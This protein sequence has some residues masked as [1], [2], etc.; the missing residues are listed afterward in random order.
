MP[1]LKKLQQWLEQLAQWT[2][3]LISWLALALVLVTVSI[4]ILRYLFDFGSI[5][6][7]ES[8]VY[9]HAS[10]F[11]LGGAYT[12]KQDGHVRVDIFY[13]R[14]TPEQKAWVNLIGAA[15]FLLPMCFFIGGMSWDYVTSAWSLREGSRE[16]G[17]L[18]FVYLLKSLIPLSALLLALQG[19]SQ[20]AHSLQVILG[21]DLETSDDG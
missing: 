5:A 15:F 4:V 9:L 8:M 17:G 14:F 7:Q 21:P 16:A 3:Q 20:I 10:L 1:A 6:L 18:P 2:G 13:Q 19:L 12:L 11:L